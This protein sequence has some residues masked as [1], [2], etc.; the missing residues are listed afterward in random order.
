[1]D[2]A[3]GPSQTCLPKNKRDSSETPVVSVQNKSCHGRGREGAGENPMKP[4]R[5]HCW[6]QLCGTCGTCLW[7]SSWHQVCPKLWQAAEHR[8]LFQ[9]LQPLLWP[10]Q[11][12]V[13]RECREESLLHTGEPSKEQQPPSLGRGRRKQ[14]RQGICF[15][16][17]RAAGQRQSRIVQ[18]IDRRGKETVITHCGH[19]TTAEY[20]L[21]KQC[22][23]TQCR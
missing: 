7:S 8:A 3:G 21:H 22:S 16:A 19:E 17:G 4:G 10:Q 6:M 13:D 1:M 18:D 2:L 20:S 9:T 23:S 11:S 15:A 5:L 14:A 12:S